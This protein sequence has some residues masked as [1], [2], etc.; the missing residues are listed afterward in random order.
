MNSNAK[1][2][3]NEIA[4]AIKKRLSLDRGWFISSSKTYLPQ[5]TQR[6]NEG[7]MLQGVDAVWDV[8]LYRY[9][10][11]ING[12][13]KYLAFESPQTHRAI[14]GSLNSKASEARRATSA[15]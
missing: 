4:S 15:H 3:A 11:N 1:W 2:K 5:R 10:S 14:Y 12:Y 7:L 13:A 8:F 9:L 6:Q